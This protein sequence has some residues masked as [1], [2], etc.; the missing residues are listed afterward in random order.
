[1]ALSGILMALLRRERTGRGD[2]LD[3]SMQDSLVAWM[4]NNISPVFAEGRELDTTSERSLGGAALYQLYRCADGRTLSLGGS[5]PKFVQILLN[6]LHRP[7]LIELCKL[8]PGRGQDPVRAFLDQT[9]ATRTL[10]EWEPLLSSLDICWAPVK[11]VAEAMQ[12]EHL[13][14][15]DMKLEFDDA[16]TQLGLPIKFSDEPGAVRPQP[17]ALGQHTRSAL[18]AVGYTEAELDAMARS[19]AIG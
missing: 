19:G 4:V 3:I 18:A 10:A 15:R 12:S 5:E 6:A 17:L 9:F 13:H 1:M 7:D 2:T 8:P 14:A 16:P 11:G